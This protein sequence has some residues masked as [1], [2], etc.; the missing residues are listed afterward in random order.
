MG[1]AGLVRGC[2][3]QGCDFGVRDTTS[4]PK[5]HNHPKQV[6]FNLELVLSP[7]IVKL[8]FC[9]SFF[10]NTDFQWVQGDVCEVQLM[11]YNPMP[12]EL[13]VENMVRFAFLAKWFIFNQTLVLVTSR[14][15]PPEGSV[16][17]ILP[18][19]AEGG[20]LLIILIL[21]TAINGWIL[22]T[23]LIGFLCVFKRCLF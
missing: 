19:S 2:W 14:C 4:L 7:S 5:M 15:C 22:W 9:L 18:S 11:V 21:H 6:C 17:K 1:G 8:I 12:F 13:R 16:G 3:S 10:F 23:V 20:R